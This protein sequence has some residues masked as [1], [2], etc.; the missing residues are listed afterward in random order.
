METNT[1]TQEDNDLQMLTR[2]ILSNIQANVTIVA[3]SNPEDLIKKQ[4]LLNTPV[5]KI[6]KLE[7][8]ISSL[9]IK[10]YMNEKLD[11]EVLYSD[12]LKSK[13]DKKYALSWFR[14]VKKKYKKH[15]T[16]YSSLSIPVLKT[17]EQLKE[18][19]TEMDKI[20]TEALKLGI[21]GRIYKQEVNTY[22]QRI[23]DYL[24]I[25]FPNICVDVKLGKV[26]VGNLTL[27]LKDTSWGLTAKCYSSIMYC[28]DNTSGSI[29]ITPHARVDG[30]C[31]GTYNAQYMNLLA[32]GKIK[33]FIIL[34]K[35][36][37]STCDDVSCYM[38]SY[39]FLSTYTSNNKIEATK[40]VIEKMN[41]E[42]GLN[43]PQDKTYI[44]CVKGKSSWTPPVEVANAK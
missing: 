15:S 8:I 39:E 2:P 20:L 14:Q 32:D 9:P 42:L 17:K 6:K 12:Y 35:D 36:M 24:A 44:F 30:L 1:P 5:I 31:L 16:G 3:P 10:T 40:P 22:S 28:R 13:E 38:K 23:K 43:I 7:G 25:E 41:Q 21:I 4:R 19:K 29:Y 26:Y 18:D 11:K 37:L 27:L 33:E 34:L